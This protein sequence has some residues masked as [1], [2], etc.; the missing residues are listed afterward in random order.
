MV[1]ELILF[2]LGFILI[3]KGAGLL[4]DGASSLAKR[5]GIPALIIGLTVVAFGTSLPELIVNVFSAIQGNTDIALGNV[6][7]SNLANILL[8]LGGTAILLPLAIRGSTV[9][10]EIPFSFLAAIVLLVIANDAILN[11]N[12]AASVISRGDGIIM[13][14]FFVIF[15]YYA[16]ELARSKS[17]EMKEEGKVIPRR[18]AETI[19][20]MIVG[21]LIGL[22]FG[23]RWIVDGAVLIAKSFGLSQFMISATIIAVGTSLPE[24]V[25]SIT[26]AFKKKLDLAVGNI[27][28]SNIF[29][30][31]LV[32]GITSTIKEISLPSFVNIDILIVL[33]VTFLLFLFVF[34]DKDRKIERWHG[35]IFVILYVAYII[36]SIMRG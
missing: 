20:L 24:L 12:G 21:G 32:L 8:I 31:F 29:N 27:V 2:V 22:Y 16:F 17:K 15:F 4:V 23:G 19:F 26:A 35:V 6:V 28:G 1:I 3:V 5:L 7:G 36:Y 34:I 11:G 18:K 25:T 14:L 10:K 9:W 13:L 33:I 30:I